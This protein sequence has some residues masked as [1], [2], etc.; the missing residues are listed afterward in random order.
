[1]LRINPNDFMAWYNL[2]NVELRRDAYTRALAAFEKTLEANPNFAP[3]KTH[4]RAAQEK[5]ADVR[6]FM[7]RS[8]AEAKTSSD[9]P[10]LSAYARACRMTGD[11]ACAE[12]YEARA[13][14]ARK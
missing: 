12:L 13:A 6:R 10:L 5:L 7:L 3:A 14:R 11:Y 2:G 9:A 4:V 1:M 8:G